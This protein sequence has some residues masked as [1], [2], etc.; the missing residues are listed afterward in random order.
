MNTQGLCRNCIWMVLATVHAGFWS[1]FRH[2]NHFV[3]LM[4]CHSWLLVQEVCSMH[5]N[6][7]IGVIWPLT[8]NTN[9]VQKYHF[10]LTLHD[11]S[12]SHCLLFFVMMNK[13]LLKSSF[14]NMLSLT[15]KIVNNILIIF[16]LATE[17]HSCNYLSVSLGSIPICVVLVSL[18]QVVRNVSAACDLDESSTGNGTLL[19][20]VGT[21]EAM[22]PD[23]SAT[24][25]TLSWY[26]IM[27][28]IIRWLGLILFLIPMPIKMLF[29]V[30]CLGK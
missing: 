9:C 23:T 13:S 19:Q 10:I 14:W 8:Y 2:D 1:D 20:P 30:E 18:N 12:L 3:I 21:E 27:S 7:I 29:K 11:L 25:C 22:E 28:E 24:V 4:F 6:M 15:L 16:R 26:N 5:N 17:P